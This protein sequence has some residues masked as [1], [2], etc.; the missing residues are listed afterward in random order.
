MRIWMMMR[1]MVMHFSYDENGKDDD[2]DGYARNDEYGVM[3]IMGY[4]GYKWYDGNTGYDG[5]VGYDVYDGKEGNDGN[6]E[7]NRN[8]EHDGNDGNE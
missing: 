5:Y 2:Y 1:M 6:D 8:D 7:Y 4:D 3:C